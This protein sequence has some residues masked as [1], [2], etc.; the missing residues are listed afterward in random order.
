MCANI[1]RR[2]VVR[3]DGNLMTNEVR[4]DEGKEKKGNNR[5]TNCH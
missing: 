3:F 5:N 4:R 1:R 2:K